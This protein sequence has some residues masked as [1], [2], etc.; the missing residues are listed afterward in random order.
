MGQLAGVG[1]GMDRRA[2]PAWGEGLALHLPLQPGQDRFG[3][4]ER[5]FEEFVARAEGVEGHVAKGSR[6]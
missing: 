6:K 3:L 5:R 4:G 1:G 2:K